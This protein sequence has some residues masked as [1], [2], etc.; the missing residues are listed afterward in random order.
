MLL[1]IAQSKAM[2]QSW[3]DSLDDLKADAKVLPF[4]QA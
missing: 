3:A 2:M 4:K 1:F